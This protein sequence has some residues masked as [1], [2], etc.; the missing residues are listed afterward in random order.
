MFELIEREL[1]GEGEFVLGKDCNGKLGVRP[2]M[3]IVEALRIFDYK[4]L[5]DSLD[6]LSEMSVSTCRNAFISFY[7]Y[8]CKQI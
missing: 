5:I 3:K 6:E 7:N 2:R 4:L 8:S 1:L